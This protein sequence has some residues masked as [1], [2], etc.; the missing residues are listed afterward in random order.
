MT[1]IPVP[2]AGWPVALGYRFQTR[3]RIVV[4]SGDTRPTEAI[5]EACNGCDVLVHEVL[6]YEAMLQTFPN[7]PEAVLAHYRNDHTS[8]EDVG[9]VA[10]Q[11]GVRKLV[12]NHVLPD[13][14]LVDE[15][16]W[17]RLVGKTFDGEVL[18][19]TDLVEVEA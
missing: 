2:H 9:R 10:T 3:D 12:L 7:A 6:H 8:P 1:A 11:A 18:L 13:N 4:V 14:D 15:A 16:E 5:V 17:I 19:G